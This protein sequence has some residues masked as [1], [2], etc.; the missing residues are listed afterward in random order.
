MNGPLQFKDRRLLPG[1]D[2]VS[3]LRHEGST[4]DGK[5][6]DNSEESH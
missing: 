6:P 5:S 1:S 3:Y 4:L 2:R